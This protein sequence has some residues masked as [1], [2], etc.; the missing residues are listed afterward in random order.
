MTPA[1]W[2][3]RFV[4]AR[5]ALAA[6]ARTAEWSNDLEAVAAGYRRARTVQREARAALPAAGWLDHAERAE[7]SA[8]LAAAEALCDKT[9]ARLQSE[10]P[11]TDEP[12]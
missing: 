1:Q 2:Q 9:L 10:I 11:Y 12:A 6:A 5:N 4:A 3:A 8:V 7:R